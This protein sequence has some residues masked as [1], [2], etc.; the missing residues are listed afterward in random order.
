LQILVL[1]SNSTDGSSEAI[2]KAYSDIR[3]EKLSKNLGY[4]GNNNVGIQIAL[5]QGANW[6]LILN[7]D[8]VIDANCLQELV[9]AGE[10]ET[11]IGILTPKIYQMDLPNEIQ[12]AGGQLDRSFDVRWRGT[13]EQ[14][15][16]QYDL[17]A[18]VDVAHGCA[19]LVHRRVFE[20]IGLFDSRFFMYRED[21]DFCLRA[22]RAGFLILYV[23]T[24]SIWHR[25]SSG[26]T[27]RSPFITYYM[28]RNSYLLLSNAKAS[29]SAY[30]LVTMRNLIWLS[31]WTLNPKWRHKHTDRDALFKAL[32]DALLGNH[33]YQ[34]YRYGT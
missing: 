29:P 17:F 30:L 12:A 24:A 31:N 11:S 16:G 9:K 19:M 1:D 25:R 13:G 32:M 18:P 3:I 7:P 22:R 10:K 34:A 33:G 6:V 8:T 26:D 21:V 27:A 23:P 14:D 2:H 5:D 15:R 20:T 28:T 4:A